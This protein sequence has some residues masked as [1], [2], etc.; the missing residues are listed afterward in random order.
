MIVE[1]L[2]PSYNPNSQLFLADYF[3]QEESMH[4]D[5]TMNLHPQYRPQ[6]LIIDDDIDSAL[7]I[8]T[9][10][11]HLGC[12]T[13]CALNWNEA[14]QKMC[15]TKPDII[16]MDWLL[17]H[18]VDAAQVIK[19]C[20]KTFAKFSGHSKYRTEHRPQIVTF[21][22]LKD[23]EIHVP[24]TPYFDHFAHWQKPIQQRE[25]LVRAL[26]LLNQIHR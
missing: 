7:K 5:R 14:R 9:V 19:H 24:K 22:S 8:E 26:G 21:S 10:F 4:K 11:L 20:S 15:A 3:Y 16:I 25:I 6:V 18:H 17:D 13:T 1:I 23:T 2:R 12:Q